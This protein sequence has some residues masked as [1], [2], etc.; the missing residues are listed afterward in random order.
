MPPGSRRTSPAPRLTVLGRVHLLSLPQPPRPVGVSL[1]G[2]HLGVV[3]EAV[4]QCRRQLLV[5]EHPDPLAE[6]EIRGH[7][8]RA[9]LVPVA[10]QIEEQLAT[11]TVERHEAELVDDQQID[12]PIAMVTPAIGGDL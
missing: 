5:S 8:R 1:G 7:E 4:E 2:Q 6:G 11:G 12:A 10:E 3:A 9:A